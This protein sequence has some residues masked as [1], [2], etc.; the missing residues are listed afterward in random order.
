MDEAN[1]LAFSGS[2]EDLAIWTVARS[3]ADMQSIF[4]QG[5]KG[6]DVTNIAVSILDFV[7]PCE[8]DVTEPSISVTRNADG[9]LT[10]EFEGTLQ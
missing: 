9:S 1:P 5:Q 4:E 7:E 6:V 2:I 8:I 10:V 3:A